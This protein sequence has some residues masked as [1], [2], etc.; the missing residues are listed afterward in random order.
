[1]LFDAVVIVWL[2]VVILVDL[3]G[4]DW[5]EKVDNHPGQTGWE[6]LLDEWIV[7]LGWSV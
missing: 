6:G 5:Q 1:M 2:G 3:E 7:I 4:S